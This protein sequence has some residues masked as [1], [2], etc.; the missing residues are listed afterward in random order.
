LTAPV[1]RRISLRNDRAPAVIPKL[2]CQFLAKGGTPFLSALT[3][4]QYSPYL[5]GHTRKDECAMSFIPK[6]ARVFLSRLFFER[7]ETRPSRSTA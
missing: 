7:A 3:V 1:E 5:F 6:L 4:S 2:A